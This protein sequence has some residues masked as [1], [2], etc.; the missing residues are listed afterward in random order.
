M[1]VN[2][3]LRACGHLLA[4]RSDWAGHRQDETHIDSVMRGSGPG[5]KHHG[6]ACRESTG[7]T[8]A[9][10]SLPAALQEPITFLISQA[11]THPF[12]LQKEADLNAM[13]SSARRPAA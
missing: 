5:C 11:G 10:G 12:L 7:E 4:N 13:S 8:L 1:L 6:G 3:K 9:H 2:I